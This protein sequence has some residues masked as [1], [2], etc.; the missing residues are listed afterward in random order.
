MKRH[1]YHWT[2]GCSVAAAVTVAK[3]NQEAKFPAILY[4]LPV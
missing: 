3:A 1:H 2:E 4:A